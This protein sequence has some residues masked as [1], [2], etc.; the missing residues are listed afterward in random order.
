VR[1]ILDLLIV[2]MLA[3][4][5][6]L[7]LTAYALEHPPQI[8]VLESGR[9]RTYTTSGTPEIDVYRLAGTAYRGEVPLAV[10]DGI[11][12]TADRDD[13]GSSL[14]ANCTYAV[15]GQFP[16]LRA[17]T[18]AVYDEEG[19]RID[20]PAGRHGFANTE[21]VRRADRSAEILISAQPQ[22]GNWIPV[23]GSGP[24]TL[25]LRL[26]ETTIGALSGGRPVPLL[27]GI[28]RLRCG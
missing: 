21:L 18:L 4:A 15:T 3:A 19:G 23:S 13:A 12:F 22:P 27:P 24:V 7:G 11:A 5:I 6:G 14:R 10:G 17:W 8:D 28:Q 20:N 1:L 26:Y 2:T 16:D 25:V 9:W